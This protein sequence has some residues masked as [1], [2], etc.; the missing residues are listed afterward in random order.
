M[1]LADGYRAIQEHA[2][3]GAVAPRLQI[4]VA[5]Q[6]RAAYLQ[7]LLTNDIQALTPGTGCYST[8]LSPQGRMHTDMHV[9]E[10]GGMILLDVPAETLDA[11]IQRLEQFIFT[12]DVRVGSLAASLGTRS[13][14]VSRGLAPIETQTG[15]TLIAFATAPGD[16]ALDGGRKSPFATAL[17]RHIATPE[18]DVRQMLT[19]VRGDVQTATNGKQRP[20][21]NESLDT[22]FYFVP[23]ATAVPIPPETGTIALASPD[24]TTYTLA[25]WQRVLRTT[26]VERYG[27]DP[28]RAK[29]SSAAQPE[30]S[31]GAILEINLRWRRCMGVE[32][33]LDQE[34][35]R[36]TVLK[37]AR[38][39]GTRPPPGR[40]AWPV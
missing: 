22:D 7:G 3:I 17:I 34:A 9:L 25:E 31:T 32:P 15:G 13:V 19:R 29:G 40:E 36:A 18:L 10:S 35:G 23:R 39:T 30:I 1:T 38:P 14:T 20:W 16:V 4:A 8:W 5:G 37:T 27:G 28:A 11:T 24:A 6:D 2:A 26:R 21:V 33:T 12:E